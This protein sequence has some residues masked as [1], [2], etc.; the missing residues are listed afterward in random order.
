MAGR[1]A[2]WCAVLIAASLVGPLPAEENS[3]PP[4]PRE[5]RAAWIA[6]VNNID[7]PSRP[8]L[9]TTEQQTEMIAILDRCVAMNFNAVFFQVRP[10][11]DALYASELEP[12]SAYLSGRQ[13]EAPDPYYDPLEFVITEGHRR[14]LQVHAWFNPFR[15]QHP[16]NRTVSEMHVSRRHPD[17]V[18]RYGAYL[19][20]D[21]GE[22]AALEHTLAVLRD[23]VERY[24]LD[25][26]HVDDYFYPYPIDG[27]DKKRIP[28]PDDVTWERY[29]SGGGQ[30]ERN[31]W[32]RENINR[33]VRGMY[34]ATRAIKPHVQV[35]FSPF[36]I[37]R[38]KHPPQIEGFD[39]VEGLF[40]DSRLW[41][42]EGWLDYLTPQLYWATDPPQQS[43]PVL[44]KWWVEQNTKGRHIWAGN[45]VSRALREDR[46]WTRDELTRQVHLTRAQPGASGNVFFGMNVL[47]ENRGGLADRLAQVYALPAL[48][49]AFPW[50]DDQPP[51]APSATLTAGSDG[52]LEIRIAPGEGESAALWVIQSRYGFSW[53]MRIVPGH[54]RV[55]RIA[56]ERGAARCEQV[57]VRAVDRCGNLSAPW[58]GDN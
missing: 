51:P 18:R 39:A 23:V 57:V 32:R 52:G 6:T 49:P 45:I 12:W 1:R 14:G 48:P 27:D 31:A 36:G 40:A 22:P 7:W 21:P 44:L 58:L 4:I 37:W 43:Y 28:F 54:E 47:A 50:L 24:D 5:M 42:Q 9:S 26:V 10:V 29:G 35:G 19:W 34:D 30:A 25:G 17:W 46:G 41:L 33:L 3:P 56:S 55:V 15:A 8:G 16:T 11:A 20:M 13:G 53:D 2:S 38:P